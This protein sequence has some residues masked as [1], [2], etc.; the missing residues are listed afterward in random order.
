MLGVSCKFAS[1]FFIVKHI[2]RYIDYPYPPKPYAILKV[3]KAFHQIEWTP[4]WMTREAIPEA[5]LDDWSNSRKVGYGW[6][7]IRE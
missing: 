1:R 2:I 5:I 6:E 3:G 7:G 4:T